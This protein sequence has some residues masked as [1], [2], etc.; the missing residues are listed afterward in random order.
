MFV[1]I[2]TCA[3]FNSMKTLRVH[4]SGI[5]G[6][7]LC[8]CFAAAP[9][10]ALA[11]MR[12]QPAAVVLLARMP[13]TARVQWSVLPAPLIAQTPGTRA[14]IVVV[15]SAWLFAPGQSVTAECKLV[16]TPPGEA[17]LIAL[18]ITPEVGLAASAFLPRPGTTRI[19]LLQGFDPARGP[20]E[21]LHGMLVLGAASPATEPPVLRITVT[22]L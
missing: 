22:A 7:A 10:Q 5:A 17:E 14:E 16:G 13:E 3:G 8:G 18:S 6:I 15:Q 1:V 2:S 11:Q 21:N 20:Q 4:W 12:S 9:P 19:P